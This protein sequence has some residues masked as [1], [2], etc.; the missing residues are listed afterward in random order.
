MPNSASG[1]PACCSAPCCRTPPTP[2]CMPGSPATSGAIRAAPQWAV[3][4]CSTISA[5]YWECHAMTETRDTDAI[6][7]ELNAAIAASAQYHANARNLA[8]AVLIYHDERFDPTYDTFLAW[9]EAAG[10]GDCSARTLC[11][12]AHKVLDA[13]A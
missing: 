8:L 13:T 5:R 12:L 4:C 6:T 9:T 7:R 10:T 11:E 2:S 1:T 3:A